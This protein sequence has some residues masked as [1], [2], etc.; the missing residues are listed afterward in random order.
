MT[1]ELGVTPLEYLRCYSASADTV[2]GTSA[3]PVPAVIEKAFGIGIGDGLIAL[4]AYKNTVELS[5]GLRFWREM[6][7]A[8]MTARCHLPASAMQHLE[9]IEFSAPSAS[10]RLLTSAPPMRGAE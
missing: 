3:T 5:P 9:A 10:T 4:S 7:C 8:Y 1:I 2:T 6:A